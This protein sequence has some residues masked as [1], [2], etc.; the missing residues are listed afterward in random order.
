MA[1]DKDPKPPRQWRM[2]KYTT[3]ILAVFV[4]EEETVPLPDNGALLAAIHAS[5]DT[6]EGRISEVRSEVT[7]IRQDLQNI[8][9]KVTVAETRIS[10]LEDT[11]A[12][13]RKESARDQARLREV[14]WRVNDAR[15]NNLHFVRFPE[16][17]EGS[18]CGSFL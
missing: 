6:L 8:T 15:R 3:P 1:R 13:L 7:L 5:R 12:T 4:P 11:V 10:D 16:E 9:D 17:A 18:D 2:D 14:A